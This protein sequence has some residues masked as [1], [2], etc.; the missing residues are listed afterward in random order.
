MNQELSIRT[1]SSKGWVV[2]GTCE[3]VQNAVRSISVKL[4]LTSSL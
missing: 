3:P 2:G 1:N 4:K